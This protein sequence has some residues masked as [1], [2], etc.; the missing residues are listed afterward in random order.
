MNATEHHTAAV[1]AVEAAGSLVEA[2]SR[3]LAARSAEDGRI[4]VTA[5][6]RHQVVA[7][8]L[9]HA[10]SAAAG[11]RV[12]LEY[13]QH[14]PLEE[15]LASAFIADAIAD[16]ASRLVGRD[17]AW[18]VEP[19]MLASAHQFVTAHRAPEFLESLAD[20][21]PRVGTGPP[22]LPDEFDMVRDTFH[23]FA[24]SATLVT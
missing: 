12:M 9:A 13:A 18:G 22:H 5:L 3:H 2:A 20:E 17:Q 16:I 24:G 6:D 7:Y 10:A 11:C 8:D 23:R 21:L 15:K 1:S 14:G 19:V 4:S